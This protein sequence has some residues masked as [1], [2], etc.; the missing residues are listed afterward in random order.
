MEARVNA[1]ERRRMIAEAAYY[2]AEQRGFA[3]GDPVADWIEAE[4]Q[5]D[6]T[7]G[8]GDH[9][10]LLARI[11]DGVAEAGKKVEALRKQAGVVQRD[12]RAELQQQVERLAELRDALE[13]RSHEIREQ[14]AEASRS[15][16]EQAESLWNELTEFLSRK[17]SRPPRGSARGR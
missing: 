10:E 17:A 16:L 12:A 13:T 9:G 7:L 15:L 2:R 1:D 5:I 4:A 11:E 8:E 14:G 3:G 6:A